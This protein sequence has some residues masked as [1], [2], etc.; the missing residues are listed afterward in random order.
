MNKQFPVNTSLRAVNAIDFYKSGHHQ[1][2]P[3]G[4]TEVYA[5]FTPRSVKH[6]RINEE[7]YDGKIV[8]CGLQGMIND[9]LTNLWKETFFFIDKKVVVG[10]YKRRLEQS[11]FCE[12]NVDHISA[13]H[14]L[15]FLPIEILALPEGSLVDPRVPVFT[16]RNTLP[17]FFW[18]TNFLETQISAEMWKVMTSATLARNVRH[19]IEHYNGLTC[20]N[21][22]FIPWQGH[23]FSFRGLSGMHDAMRTGFGHLLSF[24]GT[25]T[26][27][28]IDYAE[29][30]Y[31]GAKC[32]IIGGSV[33]ATEHSVMCMGGEE[34][35]IET[36]RRLIEDVYPSGIVSIVSDTWD[37]W[38]V[39][40]NF[41]MILKDKILA[42]EGKVVIRPDSGDPVLII[43]GDP[44]AAPGT[45]EYKGAIE[46]LWDIF[47]GTYSHKGFKTLDPHIGLIYGDSI[48]PINLG[49]ILK[50]LM[51][52]GFSSDNCVFGIGSYTYNYVSRDSAGFAIKATSG[53][54]NG[55]RVTIQKDPKT[56]SGVKKSAAGILKVV[57]DETG[58]LKMVEDIPFEDQYSADNEM[59]RVYYNGKI[60]GAETS[61]QEIRNRLWD[62]AL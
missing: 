9:V 4:T 50:R 41:T 25:D 20:D 48:S 27:P 5:N 26:I 2:Y 1:Q 35:E 51:E 38:Q 11:L 7:F 21:N 6:L 37:F 34:T 23:D 13:L 33:F 53:V 3:T 28:A 24:Y 62:G 32:T 15:G 52:K 56:D 10:D 14:D 58:N 30:N 16:I 22:G 57:K 47:G 46:C 40:T 17:E 36:F 39:V 43:C 45:P 29:T 59:Q 54:I 61:L 12:V 60:M 49:E 19:V 18:L 55:K 8:V 31:N 42:R 44:L